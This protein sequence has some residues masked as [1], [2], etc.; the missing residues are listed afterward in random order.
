MVAC[1]KK[2]I[3]LFLGALCLV[4]VSCGSSPADPDKLFQLYYVS[5]TETRVE[6]Q[7]CEIQSETVEGRIQE[8]MDCLTTLPSRLQYKAP[9]SMGFEV[10]DSHWEDGNL[11]L[12]MSAGY[13]ELSVTTEVLVRAALVYSFTQ[14]P[15]ITSVEILVEGNPLYDNLG[16]LIGKMSADQFINNMGSEINAYDMADLTLYFANASG[17]G[18][19]AVNRKKPYNT[20]IPLDRLVVEQLVAGPGEEVAG[21]VF[22]TINPDTQIVSVR[23]RDGICYVNLNESFLIQNFNVT[24]EATIYSI[25]NSLAELS[26]VNKVQISINGD[27][28]GTYRD[29]YKFSTVFE[30]NLDIVTYPD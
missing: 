30:R 3:L 5:N 4:L 29:K 17:D 22:P 19:I 16:N 9:L 23:T 6:V 27:T 12:N 8:I 15:E 10:L 28:T 18:L 1:M 7:E 11:T 25:V 21:Q 26:T 13:K 24:A 2:L 14:I 20:N